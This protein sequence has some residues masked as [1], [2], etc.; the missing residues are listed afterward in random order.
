MENMRRSRRE[1][2]NKNVESTTVR[3]ISRN[4]LK[5]EQNQW[6]W[7]GNAIHNWLN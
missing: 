6:N 2:Q 5:C 7:A 3:L 1:M 4:I